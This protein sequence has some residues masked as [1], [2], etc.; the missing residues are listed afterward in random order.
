[1][2]SSLA[3]RSLLIGFVLSSLVS[4]AAALNDSGEQYFPIRQD[5]K[6]GF[7]DK[8]GKVVITPQF[9]S[10]VRED[11][12]CFSEGLAAVLVGDKWGYIDKTGKFVIPPKFKQTYP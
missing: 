6:L 4:G 8:T 1:M 5:G 9:D 12:I 7:I 2:K 11:G 3:K 10:T